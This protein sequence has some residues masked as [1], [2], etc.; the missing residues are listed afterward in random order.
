MCQ[1]K[2]TL[3]IQRYKDTKIQ[4][5]FEYMCKMEN[6]TFRKP[7]GQYMVSL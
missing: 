7:F 3:K 4:R 6:T 5:H 1:Y 2:D